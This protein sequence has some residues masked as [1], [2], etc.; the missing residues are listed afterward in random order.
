VLRLTRIS[1]AHPRATLL[2]LALLTG[3]FAAGALRVET[4]VGYRALLGRAHPTLVRFDAFLERFDGGFPLAALYRCGESPGCASVFE[5]GAVAMAADVAARLAGAPGV[6]RV[7][8]VATT[9]LWVPGEDEPVAR[10]LADAAEDELPALA[11]RALRDSLWPR[12]LVSEDGRAAVIALEVASSNGADNR[13]AYAALDAA[14]APHEAQGWVFSRVGGP[15]EFVV[16]G[17]ELQADTARLVP[18]M[19]ALVGC[20]LFLL[21]RSL[22]AAAATLVTV[23][24]AVLW[25]FGAMGWLGLPQNSISQA[26]PP[27]LLVIGVCDGIHVMALYAAEGRADPGVPRRELLLRVAADVGAPCV[28][29]AATTA[30]GFASFLTSPLESLARFGAVA[31]FGVMAALLLTFSLLPVL[32]LRIRPDQVR[33]ADASRRWEAWMERAV[34]G[35]GARPGAILAAAGA[36]ALL[37]ALGLPKLRIDARFEDLYG[38]QSRV[39]RWVHALRDSLRRPDSLE[40]ELFAPADAEPDDPELLAALERAAGALARIEGIGPARSL[41]DPLALAHQLANEDDPFWRRLPTR[42]EDARELLDALAER[43][44]TELSRF[45]DLE[46]RRFRISLE[47]EKAPQEE[48]RRIFRDVGESLGR[49]LPPGWRFELTGPLAVVHE[50]VDEIQASQIG[51]FAA[52]TVLVLALIALFLRSAQAALLAAV[53]T[54]LPVLITLGLLGFAGISLDI[55]GTMVAAVVIG[56]ADDDAVH[57]LDPYRRRRRAGE[58]PADAMHGALLHVGRALVTNSVALAVGFAALA[59]SSWQTIASF[60]LIAAL[61]ICAALLAALFVLPACVLAWER[62]S[63]RAR[64]FL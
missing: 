29:T 45:A 37:A 8:S 56:I 16:A 18:L 9:P 31:A 22:A 11:L 5:P 54:L 35:A 42:R 41:A 30:A 60:G 3:F 23:G 24:V 15:V 64:S 4:D 17:A 20:T 12:A 32:A 43:D 47:A 53:P 49:E 7:E 58:P 62:L 10:R 48:M 25:T 39:V 34:R 36:V 57:L 2:A 59:F 27:L 19:V 38:E 33:A 1:L 51:S 13:A 61:A 63:A 14:L 46:A 28:F 52:A 26:L 44:P 6:R 55:G 50:M 40:V 21:F